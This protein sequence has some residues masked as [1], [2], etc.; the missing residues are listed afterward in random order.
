MNLTV[1]LWLAIN[2][3]V[4]NFMNIIR[5]ND[6]HPPYITFMA[7]GRLSIVSM[8]FRKDSL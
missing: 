8:L 6:H 4:S 7:L 1:C 5:E 3:R 2:R